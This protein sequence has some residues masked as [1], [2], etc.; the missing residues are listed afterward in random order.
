MWL[1]AW[2]MVGC[3]ILNKHQI[4]KAATQELGIEIAQYN[5]PWGQTLKHPFILEF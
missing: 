3:Q 1:E 2:S 4:F 5:G